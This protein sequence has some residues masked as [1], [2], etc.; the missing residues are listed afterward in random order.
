MSCHLRGSSRLI[1]ELEQNLASDIAAGRATV[2]GVS[3]LGRCDRAPAVRIDRHRPEPDHE[4]GE[5]H[6]FCYFGRKSD[7]VV[8]A[9]KSLAGGAKEPTIK[10]DHDADLPDPSQTWKIN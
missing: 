7:E 9:A 1:A 10:P 3:C 4:H 8:A 2:C 5:H 6:P